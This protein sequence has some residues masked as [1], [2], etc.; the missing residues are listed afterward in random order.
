VGNT[1]RNEAKSSHP[2]PPART[3][4]MLQLRAAVW[5]RGNW[6]GRKEKKKGKGN[7]RPAGRAK[8]LTGKGKAV[9]TFLILFHLFEWFTFCA[10]LLLL[11]VSERRL[12]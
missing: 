2:S 3:G 10:N 12:C 11:S 4:G 5:T 6:R 8:R 9:G 1:D 7:D